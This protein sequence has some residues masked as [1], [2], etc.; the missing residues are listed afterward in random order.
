MRPCHTEIGQASSQTMIKATNTVWRWLNM[1]H[2]MTA[3]VN[4]SVHTSVRHINVSM[5]YLLYLNEQTIITVWR[6]NISFE[7]I[8]GPPVFT[9]LSARLS[10]LVSVSM[11]ELETFVLLVGTFD[12]EHEFLLNIY[13]T[14]KF[15]IWLTSGV[16]ELHK[17]VYL[18]IQTSIL[19]SYIM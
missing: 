15:S 5:L 19:M 18:V 12:V 17:K 3:T 8:L 1:V 6:Y 13:I 9:F 14:I 16:H 10:V 11:Y 4:T 7:K 2:G